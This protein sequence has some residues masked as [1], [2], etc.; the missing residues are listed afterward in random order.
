MAEV[1]INTALK[2][3]QV[4][5]DERALLHGT[6]T[7]IRVGMVLLVISVVAMMW[8][9]IANDT[10]GR[11]LVEK[12]WFK[13]FLFVIIIANAVAISNRWVPLWLGAATSFTSWWAATILGVAGYLPYSFTTFLIGYLVALAV[14]AGILHLIRE[15]QSKH[16]SA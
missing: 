14:V 4:S 10:V 16:T 2:D 13:E 11:L 12:V 8:Y 6:Y 3:K 15:Y 1:N 5:L 9:H 7:L